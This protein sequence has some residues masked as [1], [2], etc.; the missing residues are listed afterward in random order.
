MPKAMIISVGGSLDPIVKSIAYPDNRPEFI[1]FFASNESV[2]QLGDI[3][4]RVGQA[5]HSYQKE[6][7]ITPDH[8]DLVICYQSALQC[9]DR[10]REQGYLPEETVVD[11][12]GGTKVMTAA[13]A[14]AALG[15]GY[16]FCYVAGAKRT[17]N[18]LGTVVTGTEKIKT[19]VGP[20]HLFAIE[21]KRAISLHVN[22]YR[23]R[24]ALAVCEN[25]LNRPGD[26]A[27]KAFLNPLNK[28]LSGYLDWESFR[29]E[30]A[31]ESLRN[32]FKDM[33]SKLEVE[34]CDPLN[35]FLEGVN[36]NLKFL[37]KMKTKTDN[38]QTMTTETV[39]DLLSNA[40]RRAEEGKFDDAVARVYRALE[41]IG[42]IEFRRVFNA[43]TGAA[44]PEALP[45]AV[46]DEYVKKYLDKKKGVLVFGLY[47]TYRALDA[48]GNMLGKRFL[49]N[50]HSK[51]KDNLKKLLSARN[52]S[53]LAHG[54]TAVKEGTYRKFA[55]RVREFS[56]IA[57]EV[58]FPRLEGDW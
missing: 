24:S 49:M 48:A 35:R 42:Q 10:V 28:L 29:H 57:D 21:E 31:M 1:S 13:L 9:I 50:Y 6:V 38:F 40:E 34:S 4:D 16:R 20:W 56:G 41:M 7:V 37:S 8:E 25:L 55:A 46:R 53:I 3:R 39:I 22:S 14:L 15:K 11:F 5:G 58:R 32:G 43:D 17:K 12:T 23:F 52:Q 33:R 51:T 47:P 30:A 2:D 26:V 18:G 27:R 19:G 54:T 36:V 45:K 44:P